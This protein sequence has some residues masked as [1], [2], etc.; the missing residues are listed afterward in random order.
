MLQQLVGGVRCADAVLLQIP[1]EALLVVPVTFRRGV[2]CVYRAADV[3]ENR[4]NHNSSPFSFFF[5][6][7]SVCAFTLLRKFLRKRFRSMSIP[8]HHLAPLS[9]EILHLFHFS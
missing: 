3:E 6:T 2:L 8:Y 7:L 5:H 1:P 9:I 4:F